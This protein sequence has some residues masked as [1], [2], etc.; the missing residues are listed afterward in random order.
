MSVEERDACFGGVQNAGWN[1][2]SFPLVG[3]IA[4]QRFSMRRRG[5]F[6]QFP[7]IRDLMYGLRTLNGSSNDISMENRVFFGFQNWWN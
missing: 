3:N 4:S 1:R 5:N 7:A 2:Y 6:N